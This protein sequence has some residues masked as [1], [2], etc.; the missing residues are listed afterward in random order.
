MNSFD[1]P[2]LLHFGCDEQFKAAFRVDSHLDFISY[3]VHF[4]IVMDGQ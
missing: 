2:S 1:F 4:D 3:F